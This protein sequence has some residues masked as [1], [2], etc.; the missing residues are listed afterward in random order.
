MG[1]RA[2]GIGVGQSLL[3][4]RENHSRRVSRR[5]GPGACALAGVGRKGPAVEVSPEAW[6]WVQQNAA[7]GL[8]QLN[9]ARVAFRS[10]HSIGAACRLL[11][12]RRG[13]SR[14]EAEEFS[15]GST[16]RRG[17][18]KP[19]QSRARRLIRTPDPLGR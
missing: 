6:P 1:G 11:A 8:I 5:L 9:L 2:H 13:W 19:A 10:P 15:T 7:N 18:N 17:L 14:Y 3:L 16:V 4:R 12:R